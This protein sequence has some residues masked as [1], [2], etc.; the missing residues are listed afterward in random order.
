MLFR[1]ITYS[2][3]GGITAITL[4]TGTLPPGVSGSLSA[5]VYTISG[6]PNASG[7]YTFTY[8][9]TSGGVDICFVTTTID[10]LALPNAGLDG[11]ITVCDSSVAPI[12]LFGLLTGAQ[13]GGTWTRTGLGTGGVFA[14]LAGTF[15]PASGASSSTFEYRIAGVLPCVDDFSVV[16]VSINAQPNA[17]T[18]GG[19][20]I[21]N[22]DGSLITL[23][24]LISGE[25]TGGVWTRT[26]GTGGL[27]V[28]A[29]GT[30]T[31]TPTT[32]T[33]T[34]EYTLPGTS[35]CVADF[36]IATVTINNQPNA[37]SD[38]SIT[39]CDDSVTPINLFGLLTGAQTGG[40]WTRTGLGTGG[41]FVPLTG[42]FTPASG[43]SS[44]TFEYRIVGVGTCVDDFSVVTVTINAQPNAGTDGGVT[45][46]NTDGSLITLSGLISGEQTGGVWTRT[47]GTGGLFVPAVGTFTPTPTTTTSTF[48]Y[49]LPGTAPCVTDFS[50]A[51]VTIN[52][53]PNAGADGLVTVCDDSIA[54]INLF[55]LLTGAQTGG[56]WTRIGPGIGGVFAPIAGTFTPLPG[57][58]SSIFRYTIAGISP[59]I[60]D[61]SEVNVTINAQPNAGTSGSTLV[62]DSNTTPIDLFTVITGAQAGG[63]WIRL[64][65]VGGSFDSVLGTYTPALGAGTSTFEYKLLGTAPCVD[66][67]SVATVN[68]N[69]QPNA[70]TSGGVTICETNTT[71]INLSLLITG[72][73]PGGTW[74]RQSGGTTGTFN[75]ATGIFTPAIGAMTS[76]FEYRLPGVAPCVDATSV[77]TVTI[78]PQPDAGIANPPLLVCDNNTAPIDLFGLIAG[79]QSG[80]LWTRIGTGGVFDPIAGTFAPAPGASSSL[81][82]YYIAATLP[83]VDVSSQV[84]IIIIAAPN[85]GV[86]GA[87][88]ICDSSTT[89]ID[90]NTLIAGQ[91]P[92]GS[93]TR[94][95]GSG[96]TVTPGG[97][98]TPAVG[99]ITSTFKYTVNG[100]TPCANDDSVAT[101]NI[102]AQPDAGV[103][104]LPKEICDN[105]TN[106]IDLF[107]LINGEQTGGT[108]IRST[109]TG[110]TFDPSTARYTP[111]PGATSSTFTYTIIGAPPCV[112]SSSLATIT[113]N[114][115]PNAGLDGA[116]SICDSSTIAIDLSSLIAG[117]QSGGVWARTAGLGGTFDAVLGT[118]TPAVGA[119]TSTFVYT[120]PSVSPC[121]ND[122]STVTITLSPQPNAGFDAVT[123]IC[124]SSATPINLFGLIT[125]EQ[126]GGTWARTSGSGGL[127][128]AAS[129]SFTASL[130]STTSSFTYTIPGVFPCVDDS[131]VVIV[132]INNQPNAGI[133]GSPQIICESDSTTVDLFSLIT[134]EQPG[135][136]WT[137]SS[138]SGGIFNNL[139]GTFVPAVGATSS[140]FTYTLTGTA[141][142]VNDSSVA[143]VTIL[144]TASITLTSGVST[145]RLCINNNIIPISYTV[146]NGAFGASITSGALPP[147]VNPVFTAGVFTISGTPTVAG[148]FNFVV[149]TSGGC[150]S[151]SLSG[152]LVV[153]P[154]VELIL[155]ST[156][157]TTL[158]SACINELIDPIIYRTENNPTNVVVTGI[159]AGITGVF[160]GG[161]F[162][163]S[164]SSSAVGSYPYVVTTVGGC[165]VDSLNGTITID[166]NVTI[167]LLTPLSTTLQTVCI[168]DPIL[169]ITYALGNGATGASLV[170]GTVPTGVQGS[171]NATTGTFTI[172]GIT[173]Q[174]GTFNYVIRTSGGCSTATLAGRIDVNP[175]PAID[176]P[177]DGYI[178][179]DP[180]GIPISDYTLTTNLSTSQYSFEWSNINGVIA[181]QT[182][183]S[184][185]AT[186]PGPYSVKVTN[187][188]TG[189]YNTENA[190]V[191]SSLAPDQVIASQTTY[192]AD[193]QVVSIT[194][195]PVGDYLYQL[196]SGPFQEDNFFVS[197]S[198]G[199]HN[200]TVKDKYGCGTAQTSFRIVNYPKFFTPNGDG[201]NDTWNIF[202]IA[203][204]P[205]AYIYIFD[206]Y[207]K[208]L[209]QIATQGIGWDGQY[210]G[211]DLSSDDYWFKVF[212]KEN[213]EF[214]EFR[215]HFSLK[216]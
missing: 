57:A 204:Q 175:L 117:E 36:S 80:G 124:D 188:T 5:G 161:V 139:T 104:G 48:E 98:Y 54:S 174:L 208:L 92:G 191:V 184:Y 30:F 55:G 83:C 4:T 158:Q 74:T 122:S 147:G 21:C 68:I 135:G 40:T 60:D 209:K 206:R 107:A 17:G 190:T 194:V 131:S 130:G 156:L 46:C 142:C 197:F 91:Q 56:L 20:T 1:S 114:A 44:S 172:N 183:N 43:A 136:T 168:N 207:G 93:W 70:G 181:G 28:P 26:G 179:V 65:G 211:A 19:V 31:P 2:T 82:T 215:S 167:S 106:F 216:R 162:T 214:K 200:V 96:G 201:Y 143:S 153:V 187:L 202:E 213:G 123:S 33:S 84:S 173:A 152:V 15:T 13:T 102:N 10:V 192:F 210:N 164:G 105:D 189:C 53:Q 141:P 89:P 196:D 186:A 59:C 32:T 94:S 121:V 157:S 129:G 27:F 85:A 150:P 101:V 110:G 39:V 71:P 34:F 133:D 87:R 169:P 24:G 63:S 3:I 134:G 8:E 132:N 148:T 165:G 52:N 108:W 64:T 118:F 100:V 112:D 12:N 126:S 6:T 69:A 203:D 14:P 103:D 166:P 140:T 72:E 109:G 154:N 50:I 125:G 16:T 45:I 151:S 95:T 47:G 23:S 127:F 146:G 144:P 66:A 119:T 86:D 199:I 90:L 76:T 160:L 138:G 81:F 163:I 9:V 11:S 159:P 155:T 38:G 198:S 18:D 178:C 42:T 145:Q 205:E 113:I 149:T 58:T 62:C 25:Q 29:V 195:T 51:T 185:T 212:Y 78:N 61:F 35:P 73:Q 67:T 37:G 41:V 79:E 77:A 115:Q 137:R 170:A 111:A 88:T 75:A 97:I 182:G 171:Y 116:L 7:T 99:A 180:S 120:L 177:Q 49:T 22:T 193:N 128:N 176:L